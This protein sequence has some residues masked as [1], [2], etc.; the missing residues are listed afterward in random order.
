MTVAIHASR[1]PMYA[2]CARREAAKMFRYEI[3][4]AGFPLRWLPLSVGAAV[5]SGTHAGAAYSLTSKMK[6]GDLGS[7]GDAE[8]RAIAALSDALDGGVIWDA[9]TKNLNTAQKQTLRQVRAYRVHVA[10]GLVPIAVEERL[11][12]ELNEGFKLTG[13]TDI[14]EDEA[15][16]DTKTGVTRRA[17][18]AQYGSY[19]LLRRSHG[20][21]ANR[22]IEDFIPRVSIKKPQPKPEAHSYPVE[23]A[24]QLAWATLNRIQADYTQFMET[25]D[26]NAFLPNPA[27]M[28]CSDKY[29]P[30]WG[31]TF[32]RAHKGAR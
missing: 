4:G 31:T 7:D 28:L 2:D 21:K 19:A 10:P 32:C 29:C 5:G 8:G 13:R 15:L 6:D 1:T 18:G 16:H 23:M 17:N 20:H 12:A 27:S 24:E 3:E 11:E 9:T 25:G 14:C 30:A 26:P 22:L